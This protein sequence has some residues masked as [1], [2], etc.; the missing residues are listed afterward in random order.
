MA[1]DNLGI[2]AVSASQTQ[3]EVTINDGINALDKA[4]NGVLPITITT[5]RTLT[6]DEFTRNVMFNLS[7]SPAAVFNLV[8]PGTNRL[9]AVRNGTTKT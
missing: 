6:A 3:K 8:V 4:A 5:H 1:S 2:P 9:F 7:G